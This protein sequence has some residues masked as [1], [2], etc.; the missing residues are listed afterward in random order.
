MKDTTF[1]PSRHQAKHLAKSYLKDDKVTSLKETDVHFVKG[2]LWD[3]KRTVKPGGGLFSQRKI[4]GVST[5]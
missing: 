1:F 3:T 4:Y 5:R 2:D